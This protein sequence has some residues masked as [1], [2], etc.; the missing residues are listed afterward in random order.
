MQFRLL[1]MRFRR[2]VRKGAR[3]FEDFSTQTEQNIER[4]FF[5]RF[6]RL[7]AVRRFVF[8][9][10]ALISLLITG[11]L[12]QNSLLSRYYQT[13]QFV[14]GGV[15]QEGVLGTFS[16][17]NPLYATSDA[18][19]T[20]SRLLFA[21]L[22]KYDHEN[23]LV[24]ELAS[25]YGV[26]ERGTTYTVKL[27][28]N[29]TW[30]DGKPLTSSDV[31]FTIQSIQNP[32][33]KSPL[34]GGWQGIAVSAPDSK[35][36]IFKL[37]NALASFP[38]NLTVGIIPQ[39]LLKKTSP[40]DLRTSE[41]NTVNPVGAGPFMWR[42]IQVIGSDPATAQER[43]A[44]APFSKYVHGEPKLD[45]FIVHAYS[46]QAELVRAFQKGQIL[47]LEGLSSLPNELRNSPSVERHNFLLTAG[48]YAFFKTSAAPFN[49]AAVRKALVQAVDTQAV[50]SGL[51]Y[52]TRPVR[53]PFLIGQLGYDPAHV[54]PGYD[55]AAARAALDAANWKLGQGGVRSKDG[56]RLVF[57]LTV[58]D[59]PEYRKVARQLVAD[60]KAV[61][62]DVSIRY[63]DA[64]NFQTSLSYHDYD[65]VL[66]GIS[67]GTDPDV[68]VYWGS[69]QSDI[70]SAN[71]LNLSE[72]KNAAADV[73]LEG[74]R[75]RLDP[76]LRAVKYKAFLQAWQKDLPAL[77]LYQPRLL[78][79]TRGP[80]SGLE[81]HTINAPSDRL[82]N[83]HNWQIRQARVTNE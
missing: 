53:S 58:N 63:Q 38:Q 70:R 54:Q 79:V 57:N 82:H 62:A 9:W 7:L 81:A 22:F 25:G 69:S 83:V 41:F 66:Y 76:A 4:H 74:G 59:T 16:G 35:T 46:D 6:S 33:A 37:P 44:L 50:L 17:A 42:T 34:I 1:K 65:A 45:E 48:T 14:P 75:T 47:G 68:F 67:I 2:R 80:I 29:S 19:R 18:D 71:R 28:P 61:G 27:K 39:H 12:I 15:Y 10:T 13:V 20:V 51:E 49:D 26:D 43:I 30:H 36:V 32:D 24:G 23:R 40:V 72:Y 11:V 55:V 52:S 56:A 77:G 3:S 60:W 31:V 21:G 64:Q 5:G 73:S 78:Y 8:G